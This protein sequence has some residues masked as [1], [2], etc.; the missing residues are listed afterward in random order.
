ML[1]RQ[2]GVSVLWEC[3]VRSVG[4][5]R[6]SAGCDDLAPLSPDH[7]RVVVPLGGSDHDTASPP[8]RLQAAPRT[9]SDRS[10]SPMT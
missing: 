4:D 8:A 9:G 3:R 5:I 1:Q 6:E 10:T 7:Q 2:A